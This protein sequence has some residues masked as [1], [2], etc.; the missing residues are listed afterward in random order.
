MER[1]K[2]TRI[3]MLGLCGLLLLSG[4]IAYAADYVVTIPPEPTGPAGPNNNYNCVNVMDKQGLFGSGD[5]ATFTGGTTEITSVTS[6]NPNGVAA[7]TPYQVS[8]GNWNF[9]IKP[10]PKLGNGESSY[11]T[12]L[13]VTYKD[14]KTQCLI[15]RPLGTVVYN[16]AGTAVILTI[17]F[18]EGGSVKT[19][20]EV[21][22]TNW[23]PR[24]TVTTPSPTPNQPGGD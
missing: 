11:D 10:G 1:L 2:W 14:G 3:V 22:L 6:L 12:V 17:V 4:R 23:L 5:T 16:P 21:S 24:P 20:R 7:G 15:M 9:D 13:I 19:H 8:S 18:D